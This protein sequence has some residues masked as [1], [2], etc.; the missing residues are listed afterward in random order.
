M[1]AE[2]TLFSKPEELIAWADTFDTVSYTHLDVYKRQVSDNGDD[3]EVGL[4][5]GA[6]FTAYLKSSLPVK[7]AFVCRTGIYADFYQL[8]RRQRA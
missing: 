4:L 8:L 7:A 5:A 2:V 6:E 3:T 1:D